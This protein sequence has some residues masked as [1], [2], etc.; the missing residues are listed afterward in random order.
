MADIKQITVGDTTYNIEPVTAYLPLYDLGNTTF[1]VTRGASQSTKNTGYWAGMLNSDYTNSTA[2]GYP[3]LP[4]SGKWWHVIS[5]DWTGTDINNWISQLALP[6]QD[7][8]VPHYRSN[9][10]GGGVSI[11]NSTWHAFITDEN[12]GSQSVSYASNAG[13]AKA[14][15]VYDWA[16]ASSKPTYNKSEV[17]LGN[18]DN[19]ADANKSVNYA[20]SSH[21]L[22]TYSAGNGSHGA[23]YYLKCRHN[24]DGNDRFK[25]QIVRSDGSVTHSTSVDYA[26]SAGSVAWDNVSSKPITITQRNNDSPVSGAY[27]WGTYITMRN[28]DNW[29]E[30]YAPHMGTSSS[31]VYMQTGWGNDR[32]G[33]KEIAWTSDIPTSLPASDVYAWAK[34]PTKP[35]YT[36]SEV[37]LGNVDDTAD[38]NKNVNYANSAGSA[39]YFNYGRGA[40]LANSSSFTNNFCKDIFGEENNNNYHLVALRTNSQAPSCLLGDYSSGIAW[41]GSDTYGSLMVRYNTSEIRVSGGNGANTNPNWTVDLVH[42]GNIGSQNVNYANS[43]GSVAW[44]N[45]TGKPSNFPPIGHGHST[46]TQSGD[47]FMSSTDKKKLDGIAEGANKITVDSSLSSTSSNPVKNSAIYSAFSNAVGFDHNKYAYG[48]SGSWRLQEYHSTGNTLDIRYGKFSINAQEK[49]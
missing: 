28:T 40:I 26:N 41:K 3:T 43:A 16:K 36:K 20:T 5:M 32:Q 10:N 15:D 35:S 37:G 21:L 47:G 8:G 22:R 30:I 23:D 34:S 45:V 24:V 49:T 33:W 46:A 6:T 11:D 31:R 39:N 7:G 13:W 18:V 17:G 38:A 29:F 4:S 9:N 44:G 14:N 48:D 25:L 2:M 42:S 27:A 19:T 12:I 1:K